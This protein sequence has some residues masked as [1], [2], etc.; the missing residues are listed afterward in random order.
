MSSY[1]D[2]VSRFEIQSEVTIIIYRLNM[3][4]YVKLYAII[5]LHFKYDR[6]N[7]MK[8]TV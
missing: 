2:C 3:L 6:D 8:D 4:L 5:R 1:I 7:K